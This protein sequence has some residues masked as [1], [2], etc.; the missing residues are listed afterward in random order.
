MYNGFHVSS[1]QSV[2]YT[3]LDVYKRQPP[4]IIGADFLDELFKRLE[5]AKSESAALREKLE[6]VEEKRDA[7]KRAKEYWD[8]LY[9]QGLE[10]AKWHMNGKTE[11]FDNFWE[12]AEDEYLGGL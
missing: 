3:H 11:P 8:S 12:S 1:A 6:A 4:Y 9:G 2:S 10:I 7:Y 5:G